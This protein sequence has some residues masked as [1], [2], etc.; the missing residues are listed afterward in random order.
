MN[1]VQLPTGLETAG[2]EQVVFE[3][4][5]GLRNLGHRVDVVS[6]MPFPH[7]SA[8]TDGLRSAGVSVHTLSV[9]KH[10]PW[11]LLRLR[12]LLNPLNPQIVHAHMFHANLASRLGG[13][14]RSFRLVNTVHKTEMRRSKRWEHY[15]DHLTLRL[16]DTQ[17]AV[18]RAVRQYHSARMG[19][20][21]EAMPVIHNGIG[22]V[23]PL[24]NAEARALRRDWGVENCSRLIGSVGRLIDEKGYDILLRMLP[25]IA[26]HVPAGETWG[27]VIIGDGPME[28]TLN[29]L[30]DRAPDAIKPI[31][32]GFREDARECIGAFDLFLMPSRSEGFGLT[33]VEAMA[34]GIPIITNALASLREVAEHYPQATFVNFCEENATQVAATIAH[35]LDQDMGITPMRPFTLDRMIGEYLNLYESLIDRRRE[36]V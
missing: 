3:L 24:G 5:I 20:A 9:K 8:L 14:R 32:P 33:L 12:S 1:I 34:H 25:A 23:G 31:F 29:R 16:C 2:A 21:P 22:P 13:I 7:R 28:S 19:V 30:A 26:D 18:S 10:T 17:T 11:R 6:L 15:L 36:V 4:S 35:V 27:L